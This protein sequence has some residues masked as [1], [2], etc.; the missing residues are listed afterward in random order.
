M[1]TEIKYIMYNVQD[2]SIL[3]E[4][5]VRPV[6]WERWHFTHM[7][8]VLELLHH[9]AKKRGW[10]HKTSL[11][12]PLFIE[13]PVPSQ[14]IGWSVVYWCFSGIDFASF[15]D[16]NIWFKNC[17]DNVVFFV[18]YFI[19]ICFQIIHDRN[20]SL[21]SVNAHIQWKLSKP[22]LP[23]INFCVVNRQVIVFIS[24]INKDF[25]RGDFRFVQN[26]VLICSR[27]FCLL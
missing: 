18:F 16:F 23:G 19:I 4:N 7:W 14:E 10:A 9:F 5:A 13:V 22:N 2:Y 8:K 24:K 11:T 12:P 27:M 15:Y 20:V 6:I 21:V 26:S 17:T 25:P 3:C 1:T